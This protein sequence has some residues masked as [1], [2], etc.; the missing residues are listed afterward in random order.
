MNELS[1]KVV[2]GLVEMSERKGIARSFLLAGHRHAPEY[3]MDGRNR[4]D[5]KVGMEILRRMREA[6]GSREAYLGLVDSWGTTPGFAYIRR[7]ATCFFDPIHLFTFPEKV[8]TKTNLACVD[9]DWERV[10]S[11]ELIGT[12]STQA[13]YP[14]NEAFWDIHLAV[15]RK[16]PTLLGLPDAGV[17]LVESD[18]HYA[19]FHIVLPPSGTFWARAARFMWRRNPQEGPDSGVARGAENRTCVVQFDTN[20]PRTTQLTSAS[21]TEKGK[22]ITRSNG[23]DVSCRVVIG[24]VELGEAGGI[25]RERLLGG[26]RQSPDDLLEPRNRTDWP[27][28][29]EVLLRLR[30]EAGSKEAFLDLAQRYGMTPSYHYLRSAGGLII[31]PLS[32]FTYPNAA[33]IRMNLGGVWRYTWKRLDKRTIQFAYAVT[34]GNEGSYELWEFQKVVMAKLPRL[35]GLPDAV[36][37]M[38][39][40]HRDGATYRAIVPP[41]GTFWARVGRFLRM[42]SGSPDP[43]FAIFAQQHEDLRRSYEIL[44][45]TERQRADLAR[46]LLR[47]ADQERERFARD[48]HD[49]LGQELV[50]IRYQLEHLARS[51]DE[52][53]SERADA[54]ARILTN[55]HQLARSLARSYDPLTGFDG[56]FGRA[57]GHLASQYQ[58]RAEFVFEGLEG[59]RLRPEKATHLYRIAQEAVSNALRHGEAT[60]IRMS[61]ER[62]QNQ[63]TFTI[64]D[65]GKGIAKM[66]EG[67][68]MGLRTIR[69]RAAELG[70]SL[71]CQSRDGGGLCIICRFP[72]DSDTVWK[73][74][75]K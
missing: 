39:S 38:E 37:H 31:E 75:S 59:I 26:F 48:I 19:K 23:R 50:A 61:M 14:A 18:L 6:A 9:W 33:V 64:A 25:P 49:G 27:T 72:D 42:H 43:T 62:T 32:L 74:P 1:C 7:F 34:P 47:V 4:T 15:K 21:Q 60:R 8:V 55:T 63:A 12:L 70:G 36:V 71:D 28:A 22:K 57:L 69:F 17:E 41:S 13:G 30:R 68:G 67:P 53:T 56:D 16:L 52:R 58:G 40:M 11:R 24:L 44:N 10:S 45:E 3:L 20:E 65:N 35:V 54:L 29:H 5:W 2:V 46:D 51:V 73:N 66:D